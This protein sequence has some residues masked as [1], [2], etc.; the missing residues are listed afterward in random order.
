MP[1]KFTRRTSAEEGSAKENDKSLSDSKRST[2]QG[3]RFKT[4]TEDSQHTQDQTS[5]QEQSQSTRRGRRMS[6]R[7]TSS[8]DETKS[9][10]RS[11]EEVR[12]SRR[13]R[14]N[15]GAD[16]A[17]KSKES[18]EFVAYQGLDNHKAFKRSG[19]RY[20]NHKRQS[21]RGIKLFN[22]NSQEQE[23]TNG[24][25]RGYAVEDVQKKNA[26]SPLFMVLLGG[27]AV[28]VVALLVFIAYSFITSNASNAGGITAGVET[29]VFIPEGA[30]TTSI[31][32][33][34]K[35]AGVIRT[36][37]SFIKAVKDRGAESML[38]PG[39]YQMTTGM[40]D[41]DAMN[42]LI[43]GPIVTGNILTVP[44]GFTLEQTAARV[45]TV[46]GIPR[47]EFINEAKSADKYYNKDTQKYWFLQNVYNNSLEGFLYPKTYTIPEGSN[48]AYVVGVLLDQFVIEIAGLDMS[49]AESHN[50][51]I[52]DV[53]TIASMVEKETYTASERDKV[54]SVIYNRLKNNM[55]LQ[56]C[57]T[58]VYV[59]GPDARDYGVNPLLYVDLEVE[60][61]YNTYIHDG[62]PPGPICSPQIASIKA[63]VNPAESDF[64]YY[65][66]TST[67]GTHTFCATDEE[68]AA[69]TAKYNEIFG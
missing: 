65:V 56:I 62:L 41:T 6:A 14:N 17:D 4:L 43:S 38:K 1:E 61:P 67:E 10:G 49:H 39:K 42:M 36:D 69:A 5:D 26:R 45:E 12:T 7:E 63:A 47:D 30:S 37:S 46:C 48:A 11:A 33:V 2:R 27:L 44:E 60:S 68:F 20:A 35:D 16:K 59:L 29:E 24:G 8:L 15:G 21:D 9:T 28:V 23:S 22:S 18:D 25:Y 31:A 55:K 53:I 66:L 19:S 54:S 13:S 58:V 50:L 64:L 32:K 51:N 40:S 34:L 3:S 52:Y 57:A